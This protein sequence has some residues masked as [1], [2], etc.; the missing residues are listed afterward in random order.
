MDEV[1]CLPHDGWPR[2]VADFLWQSTLIGCLGWLAALALDKRPA[3]KAH[4]C[5]VALA[6]CLFVPV[7]TFVVRSAGWGLL[8]ADPADER[9]ATYPFLAEPGIGQQPLSALV[10]PS[11]AR[12]PGPWAEL[13]WCIL[14]VVWYLVTACFVLRLTM[15]M[16]SLA[17]LLRG[18]TP[19]RAPIVNAAVRVAARQIG[20]R[21]RVEVTHGDA[22]ESPTVWSCGCSTTIILPPAAC[23]QAHDWLS[24][25]C[26]ELAHARRRD[27]WCRLL[28][29]IAAAV[30]PWQPFV[31]LL[32]RHY[33]QASEEACDDW[34]VALG[35]E[36]DELA[37]T[38]V[39][40]L[41]SQGAVSLAPSL[42][43]KVIERV[44]RLLSMKGSPKPELG[45]RWRASTMLAAGLLTCFLALAQVRPPRAHWDSLGEGGTAQHATRE[46]N[47]VPSRPSQTMAFA[48][49]RRAEAPSASTNRSPSGSRIPTRL[50][51]WAQHILRLLALEQV[52]SDL[53]LSSSA[54]V[55]LRGETETCLAELEQRLRS[56]PDRGERQEWWDWIR[57]I[58]ALNHDLLQCVEARLSLSQIERL[59]QIVLQSYGGA[60]L[61]DTRVAV[62][63]GLSAEQLRELRVIYNQTSTHLCELYAQVEEGGL[64]REEVQACAAELRKDRDQRLLGVLTPWQR[65]AFDRMTGRK[66]DIDAASL[67]PSNCRGARG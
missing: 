29:E 8:P 50:K 59:R 9:N 20:L 34:A 22:V 44:R 36:P 5:I 23:G 47:I 60:A 3:A 18:R 25:F 45:A 7:A 63:L 12:L 49:E 14:R 52:R 38:L 10:A 41:P 48:R 65:D 57:E 56:T 27:P 61:L 62:G 51:G 35:C 19:C 24:V 21:G 43:S 39:N 37:D 46:G 53:G 31:W 58:G 17:R 16:C 67:Y 15:S 13:A 42:R 2:V 66:L 1:I 55:V 33:Q 28:A 40:W 11:G 64:G 26:H 54:Y 6:L 32:R 30:L 4:V